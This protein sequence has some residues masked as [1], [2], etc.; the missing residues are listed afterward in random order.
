MLLEFGIASVI[1]AVLMFVTEQYL[2]E[3]LFSDINTQIA[4]K[5]EIFHRTTLD[6]QHYQ[7]LPDQISQRLSTQILGAPVIQKDLTYKFEFDAEMDNIDGE[8]AHRVTMT[9]TSTYLNITDEE[10]QFEV[11]E[12]LPPYG[13]EKQ[14]DDYDFNSVD[15]DSADERVFP[16][17]HSLPVIRNHIT[18]RADRSKV[19]ARP[20]TLPAGAELRVEF[21][22][23]A[24]LGIQEWIALEAC[25]PTINMVCIASGDGL[26]FGGQPGD[27]VKDIWDARDDR[28]ELRGAVMPGQVLEIWLE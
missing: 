16:T 7:R 17:S 4:R 21:K 12:S 27:A 11:R 10:Q 22:G 5:L 15:S 26:R 1:A 19:F 2:K 9:S 24:Y 6:L 23:I 18:S 3:H 28:W 20:S 14:R 8:P 25:L 13:F